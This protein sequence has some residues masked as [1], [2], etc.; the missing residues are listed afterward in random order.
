MSTLPRFAFN[1]EHLRP[2]TKCQ[3]YLLEVE[4]EYHTSPSS[5]PDW[6]RGFYNGSKEPVGPKHSAWHVDSDDL[7]D[8]DFD[9]G[10]IRIVGIQRF[11]APTRNDIIGQLLTHPQMSDKPFEYVVELADAAL[12]QIPN[13]CKRHCA[14]WVAQLIVDSYHE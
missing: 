13:I 1:H 6:R 10:T 14:C 8:F 4:Q 5:P 12:K 9:N 2:Y 11:P 3:T 7:L